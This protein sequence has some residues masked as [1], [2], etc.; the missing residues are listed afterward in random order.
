MDDIQFIVC[1]HKILTTNGVLS[2]DESLL[3]LLPKLSEQIDCLKWLARRKLIRNDNTCIQCGMPMMLQKHSATSDGFRWYCKNCYNC[4]VSVRKQSFFAAL[5][6]PLRII[7]LLMYFWSVELL[8]KHAIRELNVDKKTAIKCYI[9]FRDVCKW[10]MQQDQTLFELGGLDDSGQPISV[11]IDESKFFHR[12]YHRGR[13]RQGHWVLGAIER[14]TGRCILKCVPRRDEQTLRPILESLLL[15]GTHVISDGWRAYTNIQMWKGG[16][17][18]H[19]V[20]IHEREFV[21]AADP[22][23]HTN[24]I[25]NLWMRVK[26]NVKYQFGTTNNLFESYLYDFMWRSMFKTKRFQHLLTHISLKFPV[27]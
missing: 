26:R 16:V 3:T 6:L 17:Y 25:E 27:T 22:S 4:T 5:H 15:P 13:Y 14:N 1:P 2:D 10:F 18:T 12:K 19:D 8:Q 9:M 23:V 21:S 11:E 7:I 24:N 20:V